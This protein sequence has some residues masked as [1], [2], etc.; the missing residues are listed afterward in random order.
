MPTLVARNLGDMESEI[1]VKDFHKGNKLFHHVNKIGLFVD[2][3]EIK[4]WSCS[5]LRLPESENFSVK[6]S[7]KATKKTAYSAATNCNLH[8]ENTD[9][10]SILFSP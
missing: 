10:G 9:R 5:W 7:I 8:G 2:G 4:T 6:A 1:T 3:E